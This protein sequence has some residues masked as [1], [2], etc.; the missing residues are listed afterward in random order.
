LLP[1]NKKTTF[2]GVKR[3]EMPIVAFLDAARDER[4]RTSLIATLQNQRSACATA[5]GRD[6]PSF[7]LEYF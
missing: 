7:L 1:K 4:R 6:Y 3:A 5:A 2:E